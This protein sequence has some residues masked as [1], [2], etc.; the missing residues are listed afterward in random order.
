M[1]S[2]GERQPLIAV[3]ASKDAPAGEAFSFRPSTTASPS[4]EPI[5]AWSLSLLSFVVLPALPRQRQTFRC[6]CALVLCVACFTCPFPSSVCCRHRHYAVFRTTE[7][8]EIQKMGEHTC[9]ERCSFIL[10][11]CVSGF[12]AHTA[13]FCSHPHAHTRAHSRTHTHTCVLLLRCRTHM[14]AHNFF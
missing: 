12:L 13:H 6:L 3:N 8:E 11:C 2:P 1:S 5:G 14:H 9:Y 7:A 10:V 4:L